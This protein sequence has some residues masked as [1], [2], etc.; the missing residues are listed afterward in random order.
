MTL[1]DTSAW[2]EF[3]RATESEAHRGVRRLLQRGDQMATTEVVVMEVLA[4]ART[5][6]HATRLRRL[7]SGCELLSIRGLADYEQAAS[8][9]RSCRDQGRT[10]RKVTDCL[11]AAIAIREDAHLL[12]ADRDFEALAS[13]AGLRLASS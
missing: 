13:C 9:C 2:V 11:I 7:L 5:A 1:I 8:L 12:H 6:D 10:I 4:G 3:L